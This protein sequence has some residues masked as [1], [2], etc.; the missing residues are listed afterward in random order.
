[1]QA[2][3]VEATNRFGPPQ[4][5]VACEPR[6]VALQSLLRTAAE[7]YEAD[8]TADPHELDRLRDAGVTV[9]LVEPRR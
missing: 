2:F 9:H 5:P 1:M 7:L 3:I 8:S 6:A 4:L